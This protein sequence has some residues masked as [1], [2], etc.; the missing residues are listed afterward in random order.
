[1]TMGVPEKVDEDECECD[2][3]G[4]EEVIEGEGEGEEGDEEGYGES[5]SW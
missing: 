3:G 4:L 5:C 1:M 2:E